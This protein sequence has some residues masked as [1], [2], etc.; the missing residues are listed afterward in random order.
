V[1][2]QL[3]VVGVNVN[4][5]SKSAERDEQNAGQSQKLDGRLNSISA[6]AEHAIQPKLQTLY[7]LRQR[8]NDR[9]ID[10]AR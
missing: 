3:G 4:G 1:A 5:L 7:R 8:K 6:D 2:G 9:T 10:A